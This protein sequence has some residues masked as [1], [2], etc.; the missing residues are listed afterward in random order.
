[1]E[2]LKAKFPGVFS[3]VGRLKNYQLKLHI[4]PQVTPV[5]QKMRRI[6]SSLK[7]KVTAKVNELLE[8]DIIER[9]EKPTT[10]ISP[11]VVAPKPSGDIRLCFEMRR[12]NEAIVRERLPIPTLDEVLESLNGSTVFSKLDLRWGFHQI[13]LEPNSRDITSFATDDGIF[14]YKRLSFGVNAAPEKYQ[15]II[16]Q[17]MAG[18]KGVANIADDLVVHG[19]DSE[20]H[21]RNLI[22]VLER[23]KERGLTVNAEKCTFRMTKVV[24]MG[25]L[26]T[27]HGIGP[28][29]EKVRAVVEASQPQ[30]PSEV[31][32]FLGLVGFS[33]KLKTDFSTTADLLRNLQDKE[34]NLSGVKS[35]RSHFR[36]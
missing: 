15:H 28:T 4:D 36:I 26:L 18:L 35:K 12:A 9:V 13:E 5:V 14:R 3:G 31:R 24:F 22:K 32:S 10:W 8:N 30:S 2:S 19:K 7:D 16:T 1:M 6:P 27:R 20:E 17:T 11:V 29:K 25:L 34:N 23:L 21:D 33:A